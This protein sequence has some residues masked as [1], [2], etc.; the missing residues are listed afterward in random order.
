MGESLERSFVV[1]E[2][3]KVVCFAVEGYMGMALQV[4]LLPGLW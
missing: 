1:S 3:K 4:M 2:M